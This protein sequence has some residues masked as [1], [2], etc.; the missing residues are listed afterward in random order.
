MY[1]FKLINL[2]LSSKVRRFYEF[3]TGYLMNFYDGLNK[4]NMHYKKV[5]NIKGNDKMLGNGI[6]KNN[7]LK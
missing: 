1:L 7:H 2:V 3:Y 6:N 5:L 4:R